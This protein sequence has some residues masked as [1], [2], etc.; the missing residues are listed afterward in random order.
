LNADIILIDTF[1]DEQESLKNNTYCKSYLLNEIR[2]ENE[3]KSD[4]GN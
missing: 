2:E 4:D 1:F 3:D